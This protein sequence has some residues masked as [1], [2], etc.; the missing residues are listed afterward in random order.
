MTQRQ[1]GNR[2]WA[3]AKYVFAETLR[4]AGIRRPDDAMGKARFSARLFR[5]EFAGP[6]AKCRM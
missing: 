2:G 3:T 5:I 6:I 4:R 1:H